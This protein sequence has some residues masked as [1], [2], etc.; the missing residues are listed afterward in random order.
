MC[1]IVYKPKGKEIEL[2]ILKR[3]FE[4]NS[5][6]CGLMYNDGTKV[7]VH[8]GFF[9]WGAF[10]RWYRSFSKKHDIK[11]LDI[12]YHF[13]ISTSG[14]D[15]LSNCHPFICH[16]KQSLDSQIRYTCGLALVHNGVLHDFTDYKSDMN[17]TR[18]FIHDIVN[19]LTHEQVMNDF[20]LDKIISGN[21]LAIMNKAQIRL[22]GE[23]IEDDGIY[24]SNSS[25][26]ENK[27]SYG[28]YK[29]VFKRYSYS[30]D[31]DCASD[32]IDSIPNDCDFDCGNCERFGCPYNDY[33]DIYVNNH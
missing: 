2:D 5:E 28:S 21:K 10:K 16:D 25:Y 24:Y 26:K 18:H 3:C 1:I 4:V 27:G 13:R 32:Y 15:R 7:Y 11:A 17:D 8:K 23:F 9:A 22:V 14:T 19:N 33:Y 31:Y 20:P 12:V 30:Y 6:G 29:S